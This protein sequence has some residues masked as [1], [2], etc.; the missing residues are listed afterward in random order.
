MGVVLTGEVTIAKTSPTVSIVGISLPIFL[1]VVPSEIGVQ[2]VHV[3]SDFPSTLSCDVTTAL[4]HFSFKVF[5][6]AASCVTGS[7]PFPSEAPVLVT[8]DVVAV[9]RIYIR[10]RS[11]EAAKESSSDGPCVTTLR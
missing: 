3:V 8:S 9:A 7:G 5:A 10:T 2:Q 6:P 4:K 11:V 1:A